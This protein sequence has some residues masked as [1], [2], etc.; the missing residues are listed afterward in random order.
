MCYLIYEGVKKWYGMI[1]FEIKECFDFEFFVIENFGYFG[2]FF[3]V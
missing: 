3:I 2:Y 1:M